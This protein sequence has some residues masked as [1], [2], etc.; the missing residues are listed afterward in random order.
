MVRKI[1]RNEVEYG[2]NGRRELRRIFDEAKS[3]AGNNYDCI[4][5]I[6]G[7]KDSTFQLHVLTKVYGMKPLAVTHSHNW[8][9]ETGW[10]NLVNSLEKFNV[11]HIMFTPNRNLVNRLAKKSLEGIGDTCWHCHAGGSAFPVQIAVKL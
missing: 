11:D 9:S 5:G 6:S 10:Y 7:G 3:K 1:P 4:I 8:F 2:E